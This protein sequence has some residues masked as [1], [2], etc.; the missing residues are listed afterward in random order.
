[1]FGEIRNQ[2]GET[3]DYTVH[4]GESRSDFIVIIG[5]GVTGNKD[6]PLVVALAE[7]L[8]AAGIPALRMSFSG[9]GDSG[10]AFVDCTITKETGDLGSVIDAVGGRRI[11]YVGHSMGGAVGVN[12]ATTDL[13]IEALVSLAGMVHTEE[14]ARCEFGEET[15]D[16]GFMWGEERCPLST[17]YMNDMKAIGSVVDLGAQISVP[18]LLV[19]G[20]EDDLVPVGDSRDII[21]KATNSPELFEIA[22]ADHVFSDAALAVMVNKVT[23]WVKAQ[24]G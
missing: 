16:A 17:I 23:D 24:A 21:A 3:L 9:N 19:H 7:G 14:F 12:R 1:M 4:S 18:W 15:P 2:Q 11:C 22:G 13:R 8:E 5:H 10:G 6:R 20:S